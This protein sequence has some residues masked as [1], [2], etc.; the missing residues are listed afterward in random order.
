M[1]KI[2]VVVIGFVGLVFWGLLAGMVW[3]KGATGAPSKN[4]E[5]VSFLITKGSGAEKIGRNLK[6]TGLIKSAFAFK[7]YLQVYG[8]AT[9]VPPGEFE[10]TGNLTLGEIVETLL[11]GPTELWITVPEGLRREEVV[12][13]FI[14]GLGLTDEE[15]VSLRKEF[16]AE[17]VGMEGYLFPDTYLFPKD[18]QASRVVNVMRSTFEKKFPG[19]SEEAV[20]LAS[21][22]ERETLTAKERPVVAGILMN[23]LNNDWP[24]QADA[25]IQY[26]LGEPGKWWPRPL[27][28]ADLEINS[29]YNTYKFIGLPPGPIANPGLTSLNA[30]ANPEETEY[31]YYIHD[32]DGVIHYAETLEEHN[33]NVQMYLR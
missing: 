33:Q 12:E 21:I 30:A 22:L 19:G 32:T 8:L 31:W 3:W 25:T 23:R 14:E 11:K 9:K 6:E 24:L 2:S 10:L 17:S 20:I 29:L 16:L 28:R 4:E 5:N 13:K 27:T 7:V 26:A 18:I 15:A 1:K